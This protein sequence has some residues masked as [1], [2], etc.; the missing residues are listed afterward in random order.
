MAAAQGLQTGGL[1]RAAAAARRRPRASAGVAQ[2]LH[3]PASAGGQRLTAGRCK[4]AVACSASRRSSWARAT[5]DSDASTASPPFETSTSMHDAGSGTA[6]C[7]HEHEHHE[8]GSHAEHSHDHEHADDHEEEVVMAGIHSHSHGA[9]ASRRRNANFAERGLTSFYGF[10]GILEL[11][12]LLRDNTSVVVSAWV[13]LVR[14]PAPPACE[15]VLT[16]QK[17]RC[18]A[19]NQVVAG[20]AKVVALLG[21]ASISFAGSVAAVATIGIYIIVGTPEF[22]DVTYEI[23]R[24]RLNIHVRALSAL[25]VAYAHVSCFVA[26]TNYKGCHT[27]RPLRRPPHVL[28]AAYLWRAQGST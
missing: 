27:P 1:V 3:R 4:A 21:V 24:L 26:A 20:L 23:A 7:E 12:S 10:L 16:H 17:L 18:P 2:P 6:S 13:L 9:P 14:Q 28:A 25:L 22:V 11:A 15:N 19:A 8:N 5:A